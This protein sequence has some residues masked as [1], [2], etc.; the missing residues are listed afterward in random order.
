MNLKP[1]DLGSGIL[2][3]KNVLKDKVATYE[4]IKNSKN[5]DDPYFNKDT[6]KDW[7]PWGN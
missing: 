5:G 3:F 2:L 4:F 1:I 7:R 6:W